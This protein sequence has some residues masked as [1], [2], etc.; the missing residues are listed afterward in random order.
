MGAYQAKTHLSRLLE[1]V[2]RGE[3]FTITELRAPGGS[4]SAPAG[5]PGPL[6][7]VAPAMAELR[8]L[9]QGITLGDQDPK[10][11]IAP[12]RR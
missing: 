9:R 4:G 7:S 10:E 2:G 12:G 5:R 11:L 6:P 8:R 3:R 1:E